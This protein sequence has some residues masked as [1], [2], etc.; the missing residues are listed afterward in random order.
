MRFD[1]QIY[2]GHNV[3]TKRVHTHAFVSEVARECGINDHTLIRARG[4][5]HGVAEDTTI[6]EVCDVPQEYVDELRERVLP[7][8]CDAL[9]QDAIMMRV[10]VSNAE[11]IT[12]G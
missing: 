9:S 3:G 8:M 11:F 10:N 4:M 5:W 12:R 1:V 2:V 7:R 6:V